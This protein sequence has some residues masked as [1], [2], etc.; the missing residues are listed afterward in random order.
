MLT[1]KFAVEIDNEYAEMAKKRIE[2]EFG[3]FLNDKVHLT[4]GRIPNE[5]IAAA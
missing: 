5:Q 1:F 2:N 4:I 3:M